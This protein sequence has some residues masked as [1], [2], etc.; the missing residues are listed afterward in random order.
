M[1]SDLAKNKR[2]SA[3]RK[4]ILPFTLWLVTC[5]AITVIYLGPVV[6]MFFTAFKP[7][8]EIRSW[9]PQL[10]PDNWTVDNFVR[11]WQASNWPRMFFN[12]VFL[13][14]TITISHLFFSSLAAFAFARL[15]FPFKNVIFLLVLATMIV[16]DQVDLIP[17]FLMMAQWGLV[18]T[19][20]PVILLAL[21]SGLH[22][23]RK[24]A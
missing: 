1:T 22:S 19:Y 12:S 20:V 24:T 5:L 3:K 4:R 10:F 7:L 11:A 13:S 21:A 6:W 14:L 2:W 17:R 18:N 16:P 15:H 9:P 8:E 23:S